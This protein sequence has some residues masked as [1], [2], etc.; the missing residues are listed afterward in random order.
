M[1]RVCLQSAST[2][3]QSSFCR[4]RDAMHKRDY[5]RH[6]VSVCPS[7][8][9][10]VTF[11]DHDKTN[12]HIFEI[13]H[14]RVVTPFQFFSVPNGVAI[15]LREPPN[16]LQPVVRGR[17][18]HIL[19]F[20]VGKCFWHLTITITMIRYLIARPAIFDSQLLDHNRDLCVYPT[21]IRRPR[22]GGSRRSIAIP[23]GAE[24]N[25]NGVATRR[26]KKLNISLF[27]QTQC[28]NV[29]DTHTDTHRM[30]TQAALMHNIARKSWYCCVLCVSLTIET[31][32]VVVWQSCR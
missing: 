19:S 6:A 14:H 3:L 9:P 12:K 30:T 26:C 16:P 31:Y 17:L 18:C 2:Y 20:V 13:F 28:P 8:R 4:A 10:S 5:S 32:C 11:V 23:F 7:V 24:K 25:Q 27:V 1:L 29:T 22:Q 15:F 21:C